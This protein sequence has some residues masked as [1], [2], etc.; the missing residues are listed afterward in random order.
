[1]SAF[2]TLKSFARKSAAAEHCDLCRIGLAH[3]HQHLLDPVN[4]R[5]I[6]AC[7]ACALLFLESGETKYKRVPRRLRLLRNFQITDGQWDSLLVP[8]GLAFFVRSSIEK[9]VL[10]LYPSPAG[11]TES[12]L[13][14]DTWED[15]VAEN[16]MLNEMESDV[17]GLLA[18]RLDSVGVY[19]L[20]PIDTCYELVGLIRAKW[21]G[22]SG[23]AE[24]W[25]T[26]GE[27]FDRLRSAA[28]A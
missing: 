9:R 19:Y 23:G 8:I 3:E 13:P 18:N 20:A 26:V 1:M 5:L 17:E 10:A 27:F 4:R 24:M 11:S 16:P 6:C 14:L 15:I 25:E 22:L 21:H 2:A 28:N 7:D 12:L